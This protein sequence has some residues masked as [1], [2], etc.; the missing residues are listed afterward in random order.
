M[1]FL[2][3]LLL[4]IFISN[5][6]LSQSNSLKD[7]ILFYTSFDLSTT[8][9]YTV[10]D[11]HIYAAQNYDNANKA[12]QGLHDSNIQLTKGKGLTGNALHFVEKN[13]SALYYQGSKNLGY[14]SESWSGS[15]SFWLQV[16]PEKDLAPG[17][18][19]PIS[20]T[21][22]KYNDAAFWVDFTDVDPRKFRLGAIG[23]LDAWNPEKIKNNQEAFEK[24]VVT[25]DEPPFATGKWTH[26]VITYSEINTNNAVSKLYIDGQF[27]GAIQGINDPFTWEEGN[28]KIMLGLGYI[29]MIDD[30]CVFDKP[31]DDNDVNL[32]F[33]LKGGIHTLLK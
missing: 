12:K 29:G 15:F 4:V 25:V 22:T 28:A 20:L 5:I 33:N 27:Q 2:K 1:H 17:Y 19:D 23:D 31:L 13:T 10:G 21:D 3:T 18:C 32:I 9:E 11:P 16:D 8:A 6:S 30:L 7:H 24:R 26:I 14:N